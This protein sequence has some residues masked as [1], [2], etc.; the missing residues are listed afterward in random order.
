MKN[1]LTKYSKTELDYI[2]QELIALFKSRNQEI[3]KQTVLQWLQDFSQ[4]N[5]SAEIVC[6]ILRLARLRVTKTLVTFADLMS[7]ENEAYQF[8]EVIIPVKK[9]PEYDNEQEEQDNELAEL[10]ERYRLEGNKITDLIF[11]GLIPENMSL[12]E[13][14]KIKLN[15]K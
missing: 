11:S 10:I 12:K 15:K 3:P 2:K 8:T 13:F 14:L 4:M 6:R 5:Y 9:L 7:L 1:N